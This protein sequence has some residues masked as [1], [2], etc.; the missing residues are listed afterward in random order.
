M[1]Q[2]LDLHAARALVEAGYMPLSEYIELHGGEVQRKTIRS[3][4]PARQSY[5]FK[6]WSVPAHFQLPLGQIHYRVLRIRA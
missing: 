3:D 4:K 5:V 1:A 2:Q 6:P